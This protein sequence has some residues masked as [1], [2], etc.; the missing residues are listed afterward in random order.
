ME[1]LIAAIAA[2]AGIVI[3]FLV[4]AV[5]NASAT[6]DADARIAQARSALDIERSRSGDLER[7]IAEASQAA[8]LREGALNEAH[9]K[10][11]LQI[12]GDQQTLRREFQALS[13]ETL[14][15]SQEQLLAVAQERLTRERQVADA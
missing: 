14:K 13:A 9:E 7:R 11:V 12:R 8:Q 2:V 5:R 4:G 3:G 10:Y 1:F 6:R 15:A